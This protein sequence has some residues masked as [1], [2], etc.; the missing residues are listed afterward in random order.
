MAY[1]NILN[2]VKSS[3]DGL[4]TQQKA[5]NYNTFSEMMKQGVYLPD[6]VKDMEA[7]KAKVQELERP[8]TSEVDAE[9]FAVMEHAV[10]DDPDVVQAK[11][12]LARAKTRVISE[13]CMRDEEYRRLFDEYRTAVHTKYVNIREDKEGKR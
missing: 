10:K 8:K 2:A 7:L 13:L 4:T 9:I 1:E 11:N 3:G 12:R 6:L 5:D